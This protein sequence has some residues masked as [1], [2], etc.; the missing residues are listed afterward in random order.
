MQQARHRTPWR[1]NFLSA[2]ELLA[3]ASARLP[4]GV[5]D[6]VLWGGS[7][8]ELYTGGLWPAGDLEVVG[9]DAGPL[10]S[11]LFAV[12]FAGLTVRGMS[13]GVAIGALERL[14]V[15]TRKFSGFGLVLVR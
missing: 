12:D 4:F 14:L 13:S 1:A 6:P 3:R 11:E 10:T 9:S 15:T 8:V 7:A 5:P 2:M